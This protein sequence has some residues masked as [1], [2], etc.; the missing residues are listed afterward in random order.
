[1]IEVV[2]FV[3]AV[4]I[5][6]ALWSIYEITEKIG[7]RILKEMKKCKCKCKKEEKNGKTSK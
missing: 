6:I 5:T 2:F 7:N 1:M 4:L 3:F